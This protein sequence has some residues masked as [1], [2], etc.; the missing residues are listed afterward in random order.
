MVETSGKSKE[1]RIVFLDY[2]RIFAFSSVLIG[3]KFLLY[4]QDIATNGNVHASARLLASCLIPLF[5]EGGAGVVVFFLVSGYIITHVLQTERTLEFLVKRIFRIYPL[6]IVA[7]LLQYR[8]L[9]AA[10]HPPDLSVLGAQLSLFGDFF[11]PHQLL[12]ESNG[13]SVLRC[14]SIS[15][16]RACNCLVLQRGSRR[17]FRIC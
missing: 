8:S 7:V 12:V 6:Y 9:S 11:R 2:L 4:F 15:S 10:G 13:H 14:C 17:S 3:H 5:S 1:A 16:W